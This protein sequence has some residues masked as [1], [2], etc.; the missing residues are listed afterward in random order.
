MPFEKNS[1]ILSEDNGQR[2]VAN[3]TQ[4]ELVEWLDARNIKYS[5]ASNILSIPRE[6][7]QTIFVLRWMTE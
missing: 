6:E 3:D 5:I 4:K 1:F 2:I 7:D